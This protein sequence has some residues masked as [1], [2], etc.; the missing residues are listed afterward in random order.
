MVR[1]LPF[2][3]YKWTKFPVENF[4]QVEAVYSRA[5]YQEV[6]WLNKGKKFPR[7]VDDPYYENVGSVIAVQPLNAELKKGAVC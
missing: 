4:V 6:E 2:K 7:I 1:L 3:L 5:V